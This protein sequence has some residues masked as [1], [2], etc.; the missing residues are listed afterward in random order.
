MKIGQLQGMLAAML[1]NGATEETDV[2]F[3]LTDKAEKAHRS[4]SRPTFI[5]VEPDLSSPIQEHKIATPVWKGDYSIPLR[6]CVKHHPL[7]EAWE[8]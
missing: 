6:I 1:A 5:S 2:T 3:W 4:F 8:W 7:A